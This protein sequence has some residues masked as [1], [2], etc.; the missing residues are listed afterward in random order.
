MSKR[1][2]ANPTD[3]YSSGSNPCPFL[4]QKRDRKLAETEVEEVGDDADEVVEYPADIFHPE[5]TPLP[6]PTS[7]SM[8]TM[9][10]MNC[11]N[12]SSRRSSIKEDDSLFGHKW[13]GK[14]ASR[15]LSPI[16]VLLSTS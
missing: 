9:S 8:S 1:K 10:P 6:L 12:C 13:R 5:L 16:R 7:T 3:L 15:G 2:N 11:S 4:F 14:Q